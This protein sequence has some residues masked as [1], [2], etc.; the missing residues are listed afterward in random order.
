M[1]TSGSPWRSPF[2]RETER[3]SGHDARDGAALILGIDPGE[4]TV[5]Q[6]RRVLRAVNMAHRLEGRPPLVFS[7]QAGANTPD[8]SH[9]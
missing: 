5:E 8:E 9:D 7:V 1:N 3:L 2:E 4:A 6:I